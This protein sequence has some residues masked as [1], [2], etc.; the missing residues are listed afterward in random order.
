MLR[1][2]NLPLKVTRRF[3]MDQPL[4]QR[5]AKVS[6]V[7]CPTCVLTLNNM[8]LCALRYKNLLDYESYVPDFWTRR[9]S[10][11]S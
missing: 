6:G 10:R 7:S 4:T 11:L 2:L 1:R 9:I 3:A 8:A 5:G